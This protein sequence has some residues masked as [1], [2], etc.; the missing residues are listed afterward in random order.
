MR[1][2]HFLDNVTQESSRMLNLLLSLIQSMEMKT[3]IK[4]MFKWLKMIAVKFLF[5]ENTLATVV[6]LMAI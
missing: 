3:R 2:S 4:I 1:A 6:T 5:K